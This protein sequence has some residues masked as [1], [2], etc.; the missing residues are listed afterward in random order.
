MDKQVFTLMNEHHLNSLAIVMILAVII[1]LLFRRINEKTIISV[2]KVI[3]VILIFNEFTKPFSRY[4]L[5]EEAWNMVLPL[6]LCHISAIMTG[7][8]LLTGNRELF[9][10]V[11]FWTFGGAPV[12]LLTPD[13]AYTFPDGQFVMFFITHGFIM[14]G[15]FY[16]V[17]T[18]KYRPTWTSLWRSFRVSMLIMV[19]IFPLN[20]TLG[21]A[22]N[23]L[24]LRFKPQV[25]SLMDFLPDPP[26][27]IP[28]VVVIGLVIFVL[29]YLPYAIMD[30][31][32]KK[33]G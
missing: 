1:P 24:Y 21:G 22:T 11:Y 23:Y 18:L 32:K 3:G 15:A 7:V 27:H 31:M 10:V 9:G 14:L 16:A 5:F 30:M 28:F 13:L 29:T 6:H 25:G 4:F 26:Y 19:I 17:L 20:Y 2:G 33:A 12:A 8:V